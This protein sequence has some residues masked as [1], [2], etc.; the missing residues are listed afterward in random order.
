MAVMTLTAPVSRPRPVRATSRRTP[1]RLTRRG[2]LVLVLLV[3][4][5][6]FVALSLGRGAAP[7]ATTTPAAGPV[8]TA[9]V[10]QPGDTLWQIARDLDPAA[11]PA[12]R[13]PGCA[14]NGRP[15]TGWPPARPARPRPRLTRP[16]R[17]ARRYP[18]PPAAPHRLAVRPRLPLG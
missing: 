3:A 12:P 1:V 18:C 6:A 15:A 17:P 7:Q 16:P 8:A 5:L 11:D 14:L 9:I 10:V 2:R 13:W 4:V